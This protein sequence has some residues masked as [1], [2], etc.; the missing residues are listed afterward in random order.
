MPAPVTP[1]WVVLSFAIAVPLAA[2]AVVALLLRA[3]YRAQRSASRLHV[4]ELFRLF[5]GRVSG[6]IGAR[7]LRRAISHAD[8]EPF[9]D[10]MEAITTTLRPSERLALSRSLARSGHL[11]RE[12]R[13]LAGSELAARRRSRAPMRPATRPP[14][15]LNSSPTLSRE[16]LRRAR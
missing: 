3:A 15:S 8:H 12:R 4:G 14:N 10:A 7:D 13:T 16:A 11:A 9:W 6:R 2:T 1:F 5:G